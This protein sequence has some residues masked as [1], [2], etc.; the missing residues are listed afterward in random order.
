MVEN[1]GKN[2]AHLLEWA[3]L[4][5]FAD[6]VVRERLWEGRE[7]CNGWPEES[8]MNALALW[9]MWLTTDEDTLQNETPEARRRLMELVRPYVVLP[10]RYPSFHVPDNH[11]EIPLP[12]SMRDRPHYTHITP[13]GFYPP[14][15]KPENLL[16]IS[17]HYNI[18]I[19]FSIPPITIAAKLLP[20]V[21]GSGVDPEIGARI[22]FM[23]ALGQ[24]VDELLDEEMGSA[25]GYEDDEGWEEYVENTCNGIQDI[26][27]TGET[28]HSHGQAWQHYRFYGRVR[29]WDGLVALV[30]KP[31][32]IAELGIVIFRGY[33]VA[34]QNFVGNW[35]AY[36]TNAHAIPLEGPTDL[37]VSPLL[38]FTLEATSLL[39]PKSVRIPLCTGQAYLTSIARIEAQSPR[40]CQDVAIAV[41][42]SIDID[43]LGPCVLAAFTGVYTAVDTIIDHRPYGTADSPST[44]AVC[45][46]D[47]AL[48]VVNCVGVDVSLSEVIRDRDGTQTR[49]LLENRLIL[50]SAESG[51]VLEVRPFVNSEQGLLAADIDLSKQDTIVDLREYTVLP[52]FV[53]THV[54]FFLHEYSETTWEDQVTR[55]S[56]AERTIRA[57]AHARR[58]LLAGFTSVRQVLFT[59]DLGTEGAQDADLAL[60]KCISGPN[61]IIPGPR[62][63]TA[64]RAIVA[65]GSYGPKNKLYPERSSIEG[66]F[67]AEVA[68]GIT[69]CK[70]AVRRQV[71][72]GAD[73]IKLTSSFWTAYHG[74]K[75]LRR[76]PGMSEPVRQELEAMKSE[77]HRLGVKIAAHAQE[78][79]A[80]TTVARVGLNSVEHG[81]AFGD[82]IGTGVFEASRSDG[83]PLFWIPTLATFYTLGG[84]SWKR[85]SA[86][87]KKVLTELPAG[88]EIACGG[89]TGVFAHGENSLEM[90][91]MVNLGADWRKVL[92]WGT[93]NGWR[94]IRSM[95]WEH[96]SGLERVR[97]IEKLGEDVRVVGD[98][99]VPFG[100]I[101]KGFAA[102]II[103][104]KGDLERDF[105]NAIDQESI[106]FVMKGGKVYK[107]NGQALC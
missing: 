72:A 25:D 33:L 28:I 26:V 102:D 47:D 73:W 20:D 80:L 12:P 94:C 107:H 86:S 92:Q 103:A 79:T 58:T 6:R 98:N 99:E 15:R 65:T 7:R 59:Q 71:G 1:D 22:E 78:S 66:V 24:D 89:D 31:T 81:S 19:E 101:R 2:E 74:G 17:P 91:V 52:G 83:L 77:A 64:N 68:D 76:L 3:D 50:V 63:F 84:E 90:K 40:Q 10:L 85:A 36:T 11:F 104:T 60:R 30:R 55:E 96:S 69:A 43:P 93:L 44:A 45:D 88:V 95:R 16:V 105:N 29:R 13:H 70:V 38:I 56:L 4:K 49:Q 27:I 42:L 35:R 67:G 82:L 97:R 62:Y 9:L 57:T 39:M 100:A 54:H 75:G 21:P 32:S 41:Q 8:N 18:R 61:A 87:F 48:R 23:G 106:A 46:V 14:Y 34:N 53:D 5:S 37:L 51:L